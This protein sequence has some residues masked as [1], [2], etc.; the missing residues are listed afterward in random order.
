MREA[1]SPSEAG[2]LSWM[3][4]RRGDPQHLQDQIAAL[5]PSEDGLVP[6]NRTESAAI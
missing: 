4:R 6:L 1:L 2:A 3:G 5:P